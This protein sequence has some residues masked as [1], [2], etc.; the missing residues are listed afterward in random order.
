M[1]VEGRRTIENNSEV[2]EYSINGEIREQDVMPDNTIFSENISPTC[3]RSKHEEGH[4]RDSYDRG[5]LME[6]LDKYQPF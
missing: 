4:V 6:F 3:G 1:I 5:W 2:W